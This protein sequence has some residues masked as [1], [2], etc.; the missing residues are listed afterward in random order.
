M[1]EQLAARPL[2]G[3]L[4]FIVGLMVAAVLAFVF[5]A[6]QLQVA[7]AEVHL[8]Q[9]DWRP[10]TWRSVR[11]ARGSIEDR[12]GRVLATDEELRD[13]F[14][15]ARYLFSQQPELAPVVRAELVRWAEAPD[16]AAEFDLATFDAWS[17]ADDPSAL[18]A[19]VPLVRDLRPDAAQRLLRSLRTEGVNALG[20]QTTHRRN[21]PMGTLA[22]PV[23]GFVNREHVGGAGVEAT[24]HGRLQGD[25]VEVPYRRNEFG[26]SIVEGVMPDFDAS[27]GHDI[28]LT[29]DARIQAAAET[30][31]AESIEAFGASAGVVVASRPDTGELLALASLPG[32]DP[33]DF[34]VG[35]ASAWQHR[36]VAHVYEPGSTA[37]IF[38]FAAA[39]DA[40]VCATIRASTATTATTRSAVVGSSIATAAKTSSRRGTASASR[41]TSAP[42][43]WRCA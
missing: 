9:L 40:G 16:V 23:V 15:D 2:A 30:A 7:L 29:I 42:S 39:L 34:N 19:F 1:S 14:I 12:N 24:Q 18:P 38:A 25:A 20:A 28:R 43:A 3:R 4:S 37:K 11:T 8:E 17:R 13:V 10:E 32:N 22:A 41:Q 31:L 36:A 35:D 27:R 21:Y 5:R 26:V 33:V 6:Y